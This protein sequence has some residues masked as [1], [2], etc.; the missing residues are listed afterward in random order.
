MLEFSIN[1][2]PLAAMHQT[3]YC[4]L[5]LLRFFLWGCSDWRACDKPCLIIYKNKQDSS[6]MMNTCH[7]IVVLCDC[8]FFGTIVLTLLFVSSVILWYHWDEPWGRSSPMV[9]AF[10]SSWFVIIRWLSI[11]LWLFCY[12]Q[13][14]RVFSRIPYSISVAVGAN[15]VMF[16][17]IS[18]IAPRH[19]AHNF[20]WPQFSF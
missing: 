13:Y 2:R 19:E 18:N 17:N 7:L 1:P 9:L 4:S 8:L 16:Y 20:W 3:S 5:R 12:Q 6:A 14:W 15:A 10:C 11:E